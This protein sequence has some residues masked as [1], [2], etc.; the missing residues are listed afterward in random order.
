MRLRKLTI[1]ALPG[2]EPG[3][4]FEP[5]GTGVNLVVGPNA[6][7]KSSL[8]R[9]LKHLLGSR[10]DDPHALSLEADFDDRETRWNV[11]RNGSQIAWRRNGAAASRPALPGAD[12]IGLYR[13][14][15]EHLLDPE[16]EGDKDLAGLMRKELLGNCDL[17]A[18]R[19]AIQHASG[20][21]FGNSDARKLDDAVKARRRV[22][23]DYAALQR[24]EE[25]LPDLQQRIDVAEDAGQHQDH[26]NHALKLASAIDAR[27]EREQRLKFFPPEMDRLRGD[28]VGRLD[29]QETKKDELRETLRA[30]QREQEV[31]AAA[32]ERTGL[33]QEAPAGEQ[34]QAAAEKLRSLDKLEADRKN[35]RD[36]AAQA[37]AAA[38]DARAQ[39]G[40]SGE[41]PRIDADACR[42]AEELASGWIAETKRLAELQEQLKVLADRPTWPLAVAA[43]AV[44]ASAS[45][46]GLA[47]HLQ[48]T[49]VALVAGLAAVLSAVSAAWL[50]RGTGIERVRAAV[51]TSQTE[52]DRIN[53]KK[54]VLATEIGFD[55][56]APAVNFHRFVGQCKD[57][58]QARLQHAKK[59]ALLAQLDS[60]FIDTTRGVR[61]FL[62]D[63]PA[64]ADAGD[65]VGGSDGDTE[66]ATDLP[67][68]DLL[69]AAFENLQRRVA[70]ADKAQAEILGSEE[71]IRLI[72]Q[73]IADVE[74]A[75]QQLYTAAGVQ[76][77][78][79]AALTARLEQLPDW[80]QAK[81][82][83]DDALRD[84]KR[85]RDA[86]ED[87]PELIERGDV[88]E[89][90]QLLAER[91]AAAGKA[92]R[93]TELIR[94]QQ[95]ILTRLDEAGHDRKLEHAV[96]AEDGARQALEDRRDEA[97]LATATD[98]LIG[99]VEQAF[100]AGSKPEIL[101][102]AGAIFERVTAHDFDLQLRND[103][104]FAARD[105]RQGELRG[106][107]E[108]SSGT[109][110][111]LLL[112]L[113]LAWT[114]AQEHGGA[115][116]P[117]FLDEALTTS[118]ETRFAVMANSL[119]RLATAE[120]GRQRQI[121]YLS[122]RR[123]EAALWRQATGSEPAVIDLE[124]VRFGADVATPETYRVDVP[125]PVPAPDADESAEEYASRL[126]VPRFDPR[127]S[128]GAIHLFHALRDDVA[129]L[130][131]LLD[132][133]RI[134]TLGQLEALL[135]SEAARSAVADED[136][137]AYL[138]QR[139]RTVNVWTELWRQGRGR[140]VDR[141]ALEQCAAISGIFI[142]RVAD[143]A[144]H[145]QGD[146]QAL[147][148]AL[149]DG[150][151]PRFHT[152]KAD[153]LDEWLADE[154]YTDDRERLTA[155]ERRRLTLQ[156]AAP[157]TE[158]D[159]RDVNRVIGWLE[160]GAPWLDGDVKT[161]G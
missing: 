154:G 46:A 104:T 5:P 71:A 109:R 151:L 16:D 95:A 147:V 64:V 141:G 125:P 73:Q 1:R 113:R 96:A 8:M 82:A 85:A 62:D 36:G 21:R 61:E 114:E 57:W 140:P 39:L 136:S 108:L 126:G 149:R 122:A 117:L 79:R 135:T 134:T 105:A 34:V 47:L 155:D 68:L 25:T 115:T 65:S 17:D 53:V 129:L 144:E 22:E 89:R 11:V 38:R 2:I 56:T 91:D 99:D 33:A 52:L 148:R 7:G 94:E 110:M 30:N 75:V 60:D 100:E 24:D 69:R 15:V 48:A 137:R 88:G 146:G 28:E 111:Q 142:D 74:S 32:L 133:W 103:G 97:L 76:P 63:W 158:A 51:R 78:D 102:R 138:R 20:S 106:L 58:D 83:L 31:A 59:Q 118:D 84:E 143:L 161:R 77:G 50:A 98:L 27:R 43:G 55:P 45:A 131:V 41:P 92:A 80:K 66:A 19:S 13:L 124:A 44:L 116:L 23:G 37:E 160:A 86:L 49:F 6:S 18:L 156:H 101:R 72:N 12:Q 4:T 152:S 40:G 14:S 132:T 93:H 70:D 29:E 145:M 157:A 159:A 153:E 9:A 54:D 81:K 130:H 112:A 123:H 107:G 90:T 127:L 120:D 42:R 26:L 3:F 35:T 128:P 10:K 121:F 67:D 87:R 119:E 150:T 139:C